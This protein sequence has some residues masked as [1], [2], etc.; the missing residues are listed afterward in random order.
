MLEI[1]TILE[2]SVLWCVYR[3]HDKLKPVDKKVQ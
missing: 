1:R 3:Q 2:L